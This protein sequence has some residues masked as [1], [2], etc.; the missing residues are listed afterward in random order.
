[1][2]KAIKDVTDAIGI[3]KNKHKSYVPPVRFHREAAAHGNHGTIVVNSKEHG[4]Q[5]ARVRFAF[6]GMSTPPKLTPDVVAYIWDQAM[7]QGYC[8][9]HIVAYL[10]VS[11]HA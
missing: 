11:F 5:D 3:T 2:I 10:E 4:L 6:E 7:E 9:V 8:P 1:M